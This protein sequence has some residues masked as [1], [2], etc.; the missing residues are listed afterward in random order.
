MYESLIVRKPT[1]SELMELR[2]IAEIQFGVSG[3]ALI[4]DSILVYVSPNTN[5]VRAVANNGKR[6]LT[7]RSGDYRFNL[8]LE[9]GK[10]L[11]RALPH[12]RLRV[13]V[14][15]DY[16][17]FVARGDTLFCK[18]V[19]AAD[20]DIRPNEEVLVA[21]SARKLIAVGRA[22]LAGWEMVFYNRGEAVRIR[23]GILK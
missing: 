23:E 3:S 10:V 12:P 1:E 16:V 6:Y 7:L 18:H 11:N 21:D 2:E 8:H 13:Y 9:A 20:A 19:L 15:E 5:R 22:Q 4:P 17:E 14:K